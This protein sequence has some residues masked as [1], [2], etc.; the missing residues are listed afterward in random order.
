IYGRRGFLQYQLTVPDTAAETV[1][2]AVELL[3]AARAASF[4]AVLK[5]FGPGN[6]GPL[7]FPQAGW[8]LALDV[9]AGSPGLAPLLDRLD[10][11]VAEAGGRVYLSKDSRL[12]PELLPTMYPQLPCW[13]AVRNRLDPERRL[14]SDLSRRI[15]TLLG[16]K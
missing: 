16:D 1:R 3:S 5:R 4:L 6:P 9:P 7:S 12:R 10:D 8:T 14:Q 15:P 13:Q 2:Q 11:L